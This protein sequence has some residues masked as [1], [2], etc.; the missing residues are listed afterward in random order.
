MFRITFM[1]SLTPIAIAKK[2]L[3]GFTR[4]YKIL[5]KQKVAKPFDRLWN[6]LRKE[7]VELTLNRAVR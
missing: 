6:R 3:V 7:G 2:K 1:H 5:S 4:N